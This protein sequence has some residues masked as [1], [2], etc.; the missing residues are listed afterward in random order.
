MIHDSRHDPRFRRDDVLQRDNVKIFQAAP[1]QVH[2]V[3]RFNLF[4]PEL[5]EVQGREPNRSVRDVP[6]SATPPWRVRR[7]PGGPKVPD[8]GRPPATARCQPPLTS[9]TDPGMAYPCVSLPSARKAS[10]PVS[11][12]R[13]RCLPLLVSAKW[14][15]LVDSLTPAALLGRFPLT[16]MM[17]RGC[18]PKRVGWKMQMLTRPELRLPKTSRGR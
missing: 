1:Q 12:R 11:E 9:P 15:D 16:R 5:P 10:T 18:G 2:R 8:P 17:H 3:T 13:P 14:E 6:A 7:P 4:A